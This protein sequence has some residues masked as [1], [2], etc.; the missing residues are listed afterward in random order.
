MEVIL[1]PFGMQS[2]HPY[3]RAHADMYED[4]ITTAQKAE[5]L[6][7]DGVALTEHS[8][9]YDGYCPSLLTALAP[10][11]QH[12]SRIKLV[13]GT[14]LVPQHDPL[15]VAEE[16][17]VLDRLSHGRLVLGLGV[18]YRPEE[19][20]GHGM[21]IDRMGARFLEAYEVVRLALTQEVFSFEGEYYNYKDVSLK[22]RPWQKEV[23]MWVC[24]GFAEWSIKASAKRGW[25]YCTTGDTDGGG[26]IF[27]RYDD[28]AESF[29]HE[30]KNLKHGLFRDIFIMPT[31]AE[32]DMILEEDY[33]PAMND[34][35]FG[36]GFLRE[37]NPDGTMMTEVP[38]AM[39]EAM[40]SNRLARPRGTP[41]MVRE[42]LAPILDWDIDLLIARL[43]WANFNLDRN[44]KSA[45]VFAREVM[46]MLQGKEQQSGGSGK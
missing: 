33:W 25:P 30:K 43:G 45:E 13:T 39:K 37:K 26:T 36:F 32:A 42:H 27:Q 18:G 41:A 22:T 38:P 46:P 20:L 10:V 21:E 29:G 15:K 3:R 24:A 5:E 16:A 11:A 28:Y 12:T 44:L 17:A 9:W 8:F 31:E 40:I 34:Q 4:L 35:F 2:P 14:L 6:G 23:P 7:Y 19:F 1:G